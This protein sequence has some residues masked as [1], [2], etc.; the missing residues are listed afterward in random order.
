MLCVVSGNKKMM[1]KSEKDLSLCLVR[2]S[3]NMHGCWVL[4]TVYTKRTI[5][6]TEEMFCQNV[7]QFCQ[8]DEFKTHTSSLKS[9]PM[10]ALA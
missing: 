10:N 6:C 3:C 7:K 2:Q 5:Q 1:D 4:S 9:P 8:N